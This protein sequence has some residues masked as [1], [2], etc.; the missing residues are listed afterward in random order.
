MAPRMMHCRVHQMFPGHSESFTRVFG[1]GE[2]NLAVRSVASYNPMNV[3]LILAV[4]TALAIGV[5][6]YSS[7]S[8]LEWVVLKSTVGLVAVSL[9]GFLVSLAMGSA[10]E[11]ETDKVMGMN[12]DLTLP[13]EAPVE[14]GADGRAEVSSAQGD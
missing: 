13:E 3:F 7:G 10:G 14:S 2:M 9:M 4:A 5:I 1:C 8:T 6:G 12:L 11:V